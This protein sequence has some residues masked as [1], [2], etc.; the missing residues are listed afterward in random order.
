M[1]S[2][3]PDLLSE[4]TAEYSY[5]VYAVRIHTSSVLN[6]VAT[7]N[8]AVIGGTVFQAKPFEIDT[9]SISGSMGVSTVTINFD[10]VQTDLVSLALNNELQGSKVEIYLVGLDENLKSID[11]VPL[12]IGF[13][14]DIEIDDKIISLR[15]SDLM[16]R[17]KDEQLNNHAAT[18]PWRFKDPHTCKYS[19][20]E[21]WCDKTYNRCQ[22]LGNTQ[23]FRG[24]RYLP[25]ISEKDIWWGKAPK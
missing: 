19:G 1:I 13:I 22:A 6:F 21:T 23:H 9:V 20:S 4:I 15:V 3:P 12:F 18:C 5:I 10:A 16:Y 7:D 2:I 11:T 8:D 14:T 17:W 24:F 25:S